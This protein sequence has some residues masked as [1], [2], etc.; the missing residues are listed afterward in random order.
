MGYI[1]GAMERTPGYSK[2]CPSDVGHTHTQIERERERL[3]MYVAF[4]ALNKSDSLALVI[5]A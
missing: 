4:Q 2:G 1:Y 3:Y 5:N